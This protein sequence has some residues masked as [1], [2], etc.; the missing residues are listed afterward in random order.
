MNSGAS[1]ESSFATA[2]FA[3]RDEDIFGFSTTGDYSP[4]DL[5]ELDLLGLE[6]GTDTPIEL[7][8]PSPS[9]SPKPQPEKEKKPAKKR[10]SWGQELPTPTTNLPPRKRAKTAAE[11]EQRRIERVLRNRAAAQA[12]RERRR[13]ELEGLED[14]KAILEKDNDDLKTRLSAFEEENASLVK[15]VEEMQRQLKSFENTIKVFTGMGGNMIS[16]PVPSFPIFTNNA[17]LDL[18]S[19]IPTSS[20][21]APKPPVESN[22]A[23]GMAHQSAALMCDLQCL[24]TAINSQNPPA[25]LV[26][27]WMLQFLLLETMMAS[28]LYSI[29]IPFLQL[30]LS[31]KNETPIPISDLMRYFPLILW[32]VSTKPTRQLFQRLLKCS[33]AL[34]LLF[35][36]ATGRA[37][38]AQIAQSTSGRYG[39]GMTE[40]EDEGDDAFNPASECRRIAKELR[41]N[42]FMDDFLLPIKMGDGDGT[43]SFF[44]SSHHA[45][46]FDEKR[47][48]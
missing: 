26:A 22:Q 2:P 19:I 48:L 36:D 4:S 1:S 45:G 6:Q 16:R 47:G 43:G 17:P 7:R 9:V 35:Q 42:R 11:K 34:A 44:S 13:K 25:E 24:P 32:L 40:D 18:S 20:T 28:T 5:E 8:E 46:T 27:I 39:Q 31:L 21:P 15:R 33:P 37:L 3:E 30:F 41:Y 14:E 12:S 38:L 10:K 23:L 29:Q